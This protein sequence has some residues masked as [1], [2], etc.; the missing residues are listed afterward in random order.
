MAARRPLKEAQL[1]NSQREMLE[2]LWF[3]YG[4]H[5]PEATP[6]NQTF[7]SGLHRTRSAPEKP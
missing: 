7:R 5:G 4:Y 1:T 6:G 3:V 2:R